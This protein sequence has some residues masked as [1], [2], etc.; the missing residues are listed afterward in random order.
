MEIVVW[1]VKAVEGTH[2]SVSVKL[3]P[4]LTVCGHVVGALMEKS[5]LWPPENVGALL[6]VMVPLPAFLTVNDDVSCA[7]TA[8]LPKSVPSAA[9][10]V[11][12]PEGI[13]AGLPPVLHTCTVAA[14]KENKDNENTMRERGRLGAY[15]LARWTKPRTSKGSRCRRGCC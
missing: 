4:L 6:M 14:H 8:A 7:D 11:A 3:L 13:C 12:L 9:L 2:F 15:A 1:R 5:P 10:V